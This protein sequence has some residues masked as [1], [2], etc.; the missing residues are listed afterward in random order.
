MEVNLSVFVTCLRIFV[1]NKKEVDK[2]RVNTHDPKR[3]FKL[4]IGNANSQK[5]LSKITFF[6]NSH[7]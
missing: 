7:T 5:Q 1:Y 2:N 3:I 6:I 4:L